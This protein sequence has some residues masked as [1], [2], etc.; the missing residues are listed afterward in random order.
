MG[1]NVRKETSEFITKCISNAGSF[2]KNRDF[3]GFINLDNYACWVV[4]DG[5]DSSDEKLSAEIAASSFIEDFTQKPGF[6][7][8]LIKK[9]IKNAHKLLLEHTG[10]SKFSASIMVVISDYNKFIFANVGN[11]RLYHLRKEKLIRKSKDHSLTRLMYEL[12]EINNEDADKH[13]HKNTL[14]SYLGK[15][16]SLKIDISPKIKLFNDDV[17]LLSTQGTWENINEKDLGDVLK[18]SMDAEEFAENIEYIVKEN[19]MGNLNNYSIMSLFIPKIFDNKEYKKKVEEEK[20]VKKINFDFLKNKNVKKIILIILIALIAGIGFYIKKNKD[21]KVKETQQNEAVAAKIDEGEKLM[22]SGNLQDSLTNFE[23]AKEKYK[24]NPEKLKEID[25]KIKKVKAEISVNEFVG[26][27]DK[28]FDSKN[29]EGA[30]ADYNSA[31]SIISS[32]KVGDSVVVQEKADKTKEFAKLLSLEKTG[33]DALA[34]QNYEEAKKVYENIITTTDS[35]K[36]TEIIER[37]KQKKVS[38]EKIGE[39]I[40]IEKQGLD[41]YK[42][43][44]YEQAKTKFNQALGIYSEAGIEQKKREIKNQIDEIEEIQLY[45]DTITEGKFLEEAGDNE[46]DRKNYEKAKSKYEEAIQKYESAESQKNIFVV[47]N[48]IQ[49][50]EDLKNY[51]IAKDLEAQGDVFF[52]NKKY[53]KAIEKYEEAKKMYNKL[54]KPEDYNAMGEK[55]A[56]SKKKDKILGIF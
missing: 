4:V 11:T 20:P 44:K 3:T 51:E 18:G 24:D 38:L 12:G 56:I 14:Y 35:E 27:G 29:Y 31:L 55:I 10:K 50:I 36:F 46:I 49:N 17:L 7:K 33:D 16:E 47:T 6:S 32:E 8:T 1:V 22:V 48:K 21:S 30:I 19:D 43:G 23:E 5:I 15:E 53:K 39:A 37:V 25:E 45:E 2:R 54:N 34:K 26:K 52:S 28:N 13:K 40:G 9:Y 42:K 41:L